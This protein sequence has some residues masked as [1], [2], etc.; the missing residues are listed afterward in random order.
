MGSDINNIFFVEYSSASAS[1]RQQHKE[2]ID[3]VIFLNT[4]Y[5]T[6]TRGQNRRTEK[7]KQQ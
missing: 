7:A 3:D 5:A 4:Y 2:Q 1:L 6:A